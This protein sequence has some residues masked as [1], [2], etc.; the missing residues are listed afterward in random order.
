[1]SDRESFWNDM[2]LSII[3]YFMHESWEVR[4]WKN[5]SF[6][7][8]RIMIVRKTNLGINTLH[9]L[10][11]WS[12]VIWIPMNLEKWRSWRLL[13]EQIGMMRNDIKHEW[14]AKN[15][16]KK[17]GWDIMTAQHALFAKI[18]M[19]FTHFFSVRFFVKGSAR[20]LSVVINLTMMT[21]FST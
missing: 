7:T 14:W 9:D 1:M 13:I 2:I 15:R 19:V 16:E 6:L 17:N 20:F 11:Y 3:E 18:W 5:R 8:F 12:Y 10:K 21:P 4:R